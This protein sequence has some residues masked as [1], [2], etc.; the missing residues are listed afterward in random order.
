MKIDAKKPRNKS[1][2]SKTRSRLRSIEG[3]ADDEG[4]VHVFAHQ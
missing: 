2:A 1:N 4:G 3:D